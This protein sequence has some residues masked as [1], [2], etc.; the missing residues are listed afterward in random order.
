MGRNVTTVKH[1]NMNYSTPFEVCS[2]MKESDFQNEWLDLYRLLNNYFEMFFM[3]LICFVF[4]KHVK[5]NSPVQSKWIFASLY[6]STFDL[7]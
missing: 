2:K 5:C 6:Y 7:C 1:A 4:M 3:G